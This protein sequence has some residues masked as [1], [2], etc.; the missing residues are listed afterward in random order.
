M[1]RIKILVLRVKRIEKL[2]F[3]MTKLRCA[4]VLAADFGK[5]NKGGT[6]QKRRLT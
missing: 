1:A 6:H 5:Q 3:K 2:L 4:V